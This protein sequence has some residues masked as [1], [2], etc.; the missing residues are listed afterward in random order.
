MQYIRTAVGID[1]RS[2]VYGG[3]CSVAVHDFEKRNIISARRPRGYGDPDVRAVVDAPVNVVGVRGIAGDSHGAVCGG[4]DVV[5]GEIEALIGRVDR[6]RILVDRIGHSQRYVAFYDRGFEI[7][8]RE[9]VDVHGRVEPIV[10]DGAVYAQFGEVITGLR[11]HFEPERVARSESER[12]RVHVSGG[13]AVN[14]NF[15]DVSYAARRFRDRNGV[16]VGRKRDR[17]IG[18]AGYFRGKDTGHEVIGFRIDDGA[19]KRRSRYAQTVN[20]YGADIMT[21]ERVEIEAESGAVFYRERFACVCAG[22]RAVTRIF[23][24]HAV[25][26]GSKDG[27]DRNIA[28]HVFCRNGVIEHSARYR[29]AEVGVISGVAYNQRER[30][31]RVSRRRNKSDIERSIG[32]DS[33]DRSVDYAVRNAVYSYHILFF[34]E[35]RIS[36]NVRINVYGIS[37][38][39][40]VHFFSV[41]YKRFK[42]V[43]GI[44]RRGESYLRAL[45]D[46]TG[47]GRGKR[48]F[49]DV[50]NA[51]G[52]LGS[53]GG[54]ESY[55]DIDLRIHVGNTERIGSD[56]RI[57]PSDI[58]RRERASHGFVVIRRALSVDD[59][60][61]VCG[62]GLAAERELHVEGAPEYEL[63]VIGEHFPVVGNTRS[64]VEA[65]D[66]NRNAVVRAEQINGITELDIHES[67]GHFV[68]FG[69]IVYS[70]SMRSR[71]ITDNFRNGGSVGY[72]GERNGVDVI[73][74][75]RGDR[76]LCICTGG[77]IRKG[78]TLR[79]VSVRRAVIKYARAVVV[80][81]RVAQERHDMRGPLEVEDNVVILLH[82][83]N[84]EYPRRIHIAVIHFFAVHGDRGDVVFRDRIG[85]D[86][87]RGAVVDHRARAH[88]THA[89]C[90][91][92]YI[93]VNGRD[94]DLEYDVAV[95]AVHGK[96]ERSHAGIV[97]AVDRGFAVHE[98]VVDHV[99]FRSE[100]RINYR[101]VGAQ[102]ADI[103]SF[104][105]AHIEHGTLAAV[106]LRDGSGGF[107]GAVLERRRRRQ[108]DGI[109][110]FVINDG[111]HSVGGYAVYHQSI[112]NR[113]L[114]D[115]ALNAVDGNGS[116]EIIG[117]GGDLEIYAHAVVHAEREV[118]VGRSLLESF[119]RAGNVISDRSRRK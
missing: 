3:I 77:N 70:E 74:F 34:F 29:G 66:L 55:E 78:A 62:N 49:A 33:G 114:R 51:D 9:I 73:T 24:V 109:S 25:F 26:Y 92:V 99:I 43:T 11:A 104:V 82:A 60:D 84:G 22:N 14:G 102:S 36:R 113:A 1:R 87:D 68:V 107:H 76:E 53:C 47:R 42:H 67:D 115:G 18:V 37:T 8:F 90:G 63:A 106:V 17:D 32:G 46:G 91:G 7:D 41:D 61:A 89:L 58:G 31:E 12:A 105:G 117:G 20:A 6:D 80:R 56:E 103:I 111:H 118:D 69:E 4:R 75:G 52:G 45:R 108:S 2:K 35:Y 72:G 50:R 64:H 85:K 21:F 40:D 110:S 28:V 93:I 116:Y 19:D 15:L 79:A 95:D 94:I 112:I 81:S 23:D 59:F 96:G 97:F 38:A 30:S 44:G 57:L 5:R 10:I 39:D 86:V 65:V 71:T 13:S 98:N 54:I 48:T 88:V 16:S 119:A 27:V 100:V 101:A 83:G